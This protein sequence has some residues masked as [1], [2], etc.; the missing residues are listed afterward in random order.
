MTDFHLFADMLPEHKNVLMQQLVSSG[1]PCTAIMLACTC[2]RERLR[3]KT[4]G[5]KWP[6]AAARLS[7][8]RNGYYKL[9]K[10]LI[11]QCYPDRCTDEEYMD[12]TWRTVCKTPN[13]ELFKWYAGPG[14]FYKTEDLWS[15]SWGVFS[16]CFAG[17]LNEVGLSKVLSYVPTDAW[18]LEPFYYIKERF[19]VGS[20]RNVLSCMTHAIGRHGTFSDVCELGLNSFLNEAN[21]DKETFNVFPQYLLC[22]AL[23]VGNVNLLNTLFEHWP[24]VM[25]RTRDEWS[26]MDDVVAQS[27]HFSV[28]L[29]ETCQRRGMVRN[30]QEV[31]KMFFRSQARKRG[32]AE[33]LTRDLRSLV[34]YAGWTL[35]D[36]I[37]TI[38]QCADWLSPETKYIQTRIA[39]AVVTQ[40][41]LINS[42]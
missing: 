17:Y 4:L 37:E 9:F 26:I 40:P 14:Y 7:A 21:E 10:W 31:M 38:Q 41:S 1:S 12:Q 22:A 11:R 34:A 20:L 25:A 5:Y 42:L 27:D 2:K 16:G 30:T 36:T 15:Y 35:P 8:A 29:L 32:N 23:R 6:F 39:V 18:G 33:V 28:S 19:G 3:Y 13:I 24:V